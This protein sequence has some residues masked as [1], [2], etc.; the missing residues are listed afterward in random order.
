MSLRDDLRQYLI[1]W[2]NTTVNHKIAQWGVTTTN[3]GGE[4]SDSVWIWF[5]FPVCVWSWFLL[6]NMA[7]LILFISITLTPS[8]VSSFIFG[9][10][11]VNDNS[12][13][14][15]FN[16]TGVSGKSN[17]RSKKRNFYM[18]SI[19]IAPLQRVADWHLRVY[20]KRLC[21]ECLCWYYRDLCDCNNKGQQLVFQ[22]NQ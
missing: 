6:V 17:V 21:W 19:R 14:V 15:G 1:C 16:L 12:R 20:C 4:W 7:S 8:L 10:P 5:L 3:G 13:S 9:P 11:L 2:C 18:P 22:L